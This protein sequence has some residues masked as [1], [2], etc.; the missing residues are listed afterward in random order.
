MRPAIRHQADGLQDAYSDATKTVNPEAS[1]TRQEQ[2]Q[3]ADINI[4]LKRFGVGQQLRGDARFGEYDDNTDLQTALESIRLAK[5]ANYAVPPELREKYPNW[6]AV[7]EGAENGQYEKDLQ[8]HKAKQ[9]A[10]ARAQEKV[11]LR[12]AA[13]LN[14]EIAA[15]MRAEEAASL[16][17]R[18]P[19][20]TPKP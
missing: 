2:A 10:E 3:D 5:A 16:A 8:A 17:R 1:L 18:A 19:T 20:D 4:L 6:R 9:A 11:R 15:D 13:E 12:Q 7:L 14:R